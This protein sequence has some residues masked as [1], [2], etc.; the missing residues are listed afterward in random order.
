MQLCTNSFVLFSR[1]Y[2]YVPRPKSYLL[3]P[4]AVGRVFVLLGAG[5]FL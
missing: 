5:L 3:L 1:L 4:E 2:T